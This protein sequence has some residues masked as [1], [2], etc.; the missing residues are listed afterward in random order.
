[1]KFLKERHEEDL[2]SLILKTTT[3]K[4]AYEDK[5]EKVKKL[6]A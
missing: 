3:E 6:S 4:K 5:L 1:M 2:A